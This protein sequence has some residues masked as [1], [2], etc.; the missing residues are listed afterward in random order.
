M[1][2]AVPPKPISRP[3]LKHKQQRPTA[4][5]QTRQQ[6]ASDFH[7]QPMRPNQ[8]F[9]A[10]TRVARN[11][12]DIIRAIGEGASSASESSVTDVSYTSSQ[13]IHPSHLSPSLSPSPN[14]F[15]ATSG[16]YSINQRRHLDASAQ[17]HANSAASDDWAPSPS[18][19]LTRDAL[20]S[21]D[22]ASNGHNVYS[23]SPDSAV[24]SFCSTNFSD[25]DQRGSRGTT[26]YADDERFTDVSPD[27]SLWASDPVDDV[28]SDIV[29]DENSPPAEPAGD[30]LV[31]HVAPEDLRGSSLQLTLSPPVE[32]AY[33]ES[34]LAPPP[35]YE[36]YSAA[37]VVEDYIPAPVVEE[38]TEIV[39]EGPSGPPVITPEYRKLADH[40]SEWVADWLWDLVN[41]PNFDVVL[42]MKSN[43]VGRQ[44][45]S[46]T[47][48]VQLLT[49]H[50]RH[51]EHN[52]APAFLAEN[53]RSILLATLLQPSAVFLALW[54]IKRLPVYNVNG[55]AQRFR[56][57][58]FGEGDYPAGSE[59]KRA[60]EL[61]APFKLF[62][63]GV[64]LASKMLDD[65]TFSN[66]V[67]HEISQITIREINTLELASLEL[68]DH[69][70]TV[71]SDVWPKWLETLRY[72][73]IACAPYPAP[74]GPAR[75]TPHGAILH[76]LNTLIDAN[77]SRPNAYDGPIFLGIEER[78]AQ[79][80]KALC[81]VFDIDEM[82]EDGPIREEYRRSRRPS[83]EVPTRL[84]PPDLP[85]PAAWQ[86]ALDP[87]VPRASKNATYQQWPSADTYTTTFSYGIP[88]YAPVEQTIPRS[89]YWNARAAYSFPTP[90]DVAYTAHTYF[91]AP[92]YCVATCCT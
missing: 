86:P 2:H 32:N 68:F 91:P 22:A 71:P 1:P 62:V 75:E 82:D 10:W 76:L 67:W 43:A 7:V 85:P 11:H 27:S 54:Y 30:Y 52:V 40:L 46:S 13:G 37:P 51:R 5:A 3:I 70:L 56:S 59:H 9:E 26:N 55:A 79:R 83:N 64:L 6:L 84:P 8:T 77:A 66:K 58:L 49:S 57:V 39:I 44:V 81:L 48:S 34:A 92:A 15:V 17:Q 50:S 74:I 63:N 36:D 38:Y 80:L 42:A 69:D 23:P 78:I 47:S 16:W 25:I 20:Y 33:E 41:S 31:S 65:T 61:Y 72:T 18:A 60:L 90:P 19:P 4:R 21:L 73:H 89:Y 12:A 45:C 28:V 88:A 53:I 35:A 24:I 14:V 29:F 87:I